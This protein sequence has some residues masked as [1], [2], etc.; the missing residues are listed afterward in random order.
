MTKLLYAEEGNDMTEE[1]SVA[2]IQ[3][4]VVC[5]Q[6]EL[7]GMQAENKQ[8][9]LLGQSLA[10]VQSDFTDLQN[11]YEIGYNDVMGYFHR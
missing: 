11:R 4:Q 3:S 8:R 9:E 5:A 6:I 1:Q 10:Y 7:A 2:F